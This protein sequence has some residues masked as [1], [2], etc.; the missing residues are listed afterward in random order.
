LRI[1]AIGR[2]TFCLAS[3]PTC[4]HRESGCSIEADG[5]TLDD[6]SF[7]RSTGLSSVN[8]SP[9]AVRARLNLGLLET[10]Q[11]DLERAEVLLSDSYAKAG[12]LSN[13]NLVAS[14]LLSLGASTVVRFCI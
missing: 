11:Q 8:P 1:N 3:P 14:S 13:Q 7:H 2:I 12:R 5:P 6:F 9:I 10:L 4:V